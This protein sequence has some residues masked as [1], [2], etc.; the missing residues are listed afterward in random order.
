MPFEYPDN[1]A[2]FYDVIYHSIRDGVDNNY[3]HQ[4]IKEA[5]GPVLEIGAGTG[6]LFKW[7]LDHGTD[8]YAIDVS[9]SMLKVLKSKI[10]EEDYFRVSLQNATHF[11]L[12]KRF[13][14]VVAPF[15]VFSHILTPGD[16]INALNNIYEH[17]S[18]GGAFIFDLYVPDLKLLVEGFRDFIDFE[19]EIPGGEKVRRKVSTQNDL[20]NQITHIRF[21]ME[22]TEKGE[23]KTEDWDFDF[24]FYFRYEIEHLVARSKFGSCK[25]SG[26]FLGGELKRNSKEF[27]IHCTR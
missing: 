3:Y 19:K 1:F 27:I 24:R 8:I 6:R 14:L 20:I 10:R 2:R 25:I 22:W 21:R 23:W 18:P 4:K 5:S 13:S 16:Q 7:A 15:R 26:D 17:L 12:D 9:P 11:R